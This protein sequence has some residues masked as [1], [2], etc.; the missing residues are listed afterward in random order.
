MSQDESKMECPAEGAGP[1]LAHL[2]LLRPES[3]VGFYTPMPP[4][5]GGGFH[6]SRAFR[7]AWERWGEGLLKALDG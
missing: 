1:V 3:A 6:R 7:R 2:S 5:V 4:E